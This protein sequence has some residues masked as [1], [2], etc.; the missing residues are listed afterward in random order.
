MV[1]QKWILLVLVGTV[2]IC[3]AV[4]ENCVQ[5]N[6]DDPECIS[7]E[8]QAEPCPAAA[9]PA[10][11][12]YVRITGGK[13]DRGCSSQAQQSTCSE[14]DGT[15]CKRCS[16]NGCNKFPWPRCHQC[17]SIDENCSEEKVGEGTFC[18]KYKPR[19]QAGGKC[20]ERFAQGK[21]E[22]GC[23]I[24][25]IST[26]E[27]VC[28]GNEECRSCDT[29]DG[30]NKDAGRV[31]QVTKCV[32]C[33]TNDDAEGTCLDGTK[34]ATSCANPS[35][36]KCYSRVLADGSL[37]QGC[38]SELE[39]AEVTA[40]TGPTC[41]ICD[42][43]ECNKGVFPANRLVCN[44]CKKSDTDADCAAELTGN[45]KSKVCKK[46][47][48]ND[49][50]YSRVKAD[51]SF[52][53]GCQSDLPENEQGCTGL[54]NCFECEG[55]NCNT[56]SEE[57]LKASTK[58]QR[59][60]SDDPLCVAGTAPAQSC[61][62]EN[63]VCFVR[64]NSDRKLERGC[65]S[66]LTDEADKLKC[67]SETDLTCVGC[68]ASS[69]DAA[70]NNQKWLKCHK[71]S[72]ADNQNCANEQVGYPEFCTN[73]KESDKC[74][75]RFVDGKEVQRGCEADLSPETENVCVANQQCKTCTGED[76]C[77]KDVSTAFRNTKCVRCKSSED[78]ADGSCLKGTKAPEDCPDPDGKCFSRII[79]GG[80]L[81][82]G[83]R[84]ALTAQE[85]TAC[86]GELCSLCGEAGCNNAV[87][88]AN[89]PQC[90]QCV[91]TADDKSC[92]AELTGDV[93]SGVCKVYKE[94]DKCYSRVTASLNFERGCQSDL[95]ENAKTCDGLSDCL[96]CEGSNCNGLSEEKL[97]SRAKCLQCNSD[98]QTCLEASAQAAANCDNLED[99]CFVRI[100]NGKL[101]RNCLSTLSAT[102]QA[103]CNSATDL[104]CV[105]CTGAGCNVQK[106]IKCHQCKETAS[107]T[108]N[109]V[110]VDANAA[111]CSKYKENNQCYERLESEKV[112]RGCANDLSEA[113]CLDNLECKVCEG[114]ACNKEAASTLQTTQRCLQCTTANDAAGLCLAGTTST[115]PCKKDSESKCFMQVQTD[116]HLKR[117]C[118]GD[119]TAGEVTACTGDS[120]KICNEPSCNK[121]VYPEGRLRCY[122]CK[123]SDDE[124]C[125]NDLQG[126]EKSAFCKLYKAGDKC[127]SRDASDDLFE[128]GCQSDLGLTADACKDLDSLHCRSCDGENCNGISK[129]T[130][131]GAGT[132]ALNVV[133]LGIVLVLGLFSVL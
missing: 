103:K 88:P 99:S 19:D 114:N 56:L 117:G 49:R 62:Q 102:D 77:N 130:L 100:E 28:Q 104:S 30:C 51:Q 65:M 12:C 3:E 50:C 122:Q 29:G 106:W 67:N 26:P 131:N 80:I 64:I 98:D 42:G 39:P 55:N 73:Y 78:A 13:V 25:L 22:R 95:G 16:T 75:E 33:D 38:Y 53:R 14:A 112:V 57:K 115:L 108:C 85:Q 110:Q 58:C 89:R 43:D 127:Y 84:S 70:C 4:V 20:Y 45:A 97:K 40:C 37:K 60:N 124:N 72:G 132:I 2:L 107:S 101:E 133:L 71:C 68:K 76:G 92:A 118:K 94:G 9:S 27:D 91:T 44:Q 54:V 15:A 121:G 24:D 46:Y 105:A 1:Q 21:V 52:E 86:T 74:Y 18:G 109:A 83:C 93:K 23:E 66:S 96:E 10:E 8:K 113:P 126:P 87:F 7:G 11:S 79:A 90:Y 47:V 6:T 120:C 125:N 69:A 5:C 35:D 116:G 82:R 111:F 31:F 41:T 129:K 34:T 48:E 36:K 128:R 59:C 81:E 17:T 123:S 119:L 32:Q 63:D 61:G